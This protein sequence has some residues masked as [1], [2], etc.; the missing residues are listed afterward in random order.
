MS[1]DNTIL[2]GIIGSLVTILASK[3]FEFIK[4]HIQ[5]K[6]SLKKLFFEKKINSAEAAA[7]HWSYLRSTIKSFSA[8]L[9]AATNTEDVGYE[10]EFLGNFAESLSHQLKKIEEPDKLVYSVFLYFDIDDNAV[11][12]IN[13][14][15]ECCMTI[16]S[17]KPQIIEYIND[18]E[19]KKDTQ[20]DK[21]VEETRNKAYKLFID[22]FVK[23]AKLFKEVNIDY[24]G[25]VKKLRTEFKYYS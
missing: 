8:I 20:N 25:L 5:H 15:I 11:E 3:I 16:E 12:K 19:Q 22:A 9:E 21:K 14:I 23:L 4:M 6:Q 2:G 13:D 17:L 24:Y 18:K 1:I 10:S 7:S